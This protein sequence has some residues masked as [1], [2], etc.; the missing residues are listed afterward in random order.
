MVC[1]NKKAYTLI[2]SI[3]MCCSCKSKKLQCGIRR[4]CSAVELRIRQRPSTKKHV[5]LFVNCWDL[6]AAAPQR[7]NKS[8]LGQ[9]TVS[10]I[11]GCQHGEVGSSATRANVK[12][13][14]LCWELSWQ[15]YRIVIIAEEQL[16][17]CLFFFHRLSLQKYGYSFWGRPGVQQQGIAK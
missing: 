6:K 2:Q 11:S 13:L 4:R 10:T 8:K 12:P 14:K 16:M 15:N 7:R 5:S 17:V 1:I 9:M 3:E